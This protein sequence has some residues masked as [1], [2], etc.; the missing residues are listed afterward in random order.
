MG[1]LEMQQ[2]GRVRASLLSFCQKN[3]QI[4]I[5]GAGNYAESCL[6][7]LREIGIVPQGFI[8]TENTLGG[9]FRG[10]PVYEAVTI[11]EDLNERCGIIA[12]FMGANEL[13]LR[14]FIGDAPAIFTLPD[15]VFC[16]FADTV[17]V[18][19]FLSEFQK[20]TKPKPLKPL[21]QWKRILVIR[22]DVLGDLIM[23]TAFLRELRRDCPDAH[24]TLVVHKSNYFLF[25][26]CP[27][28][29]EL[30]LYDGPVMGG[31]ADAQLNHR[32]EIEER[33]RSFNKEHW[34]H[35]EQY[36]VVF[37]PCILLQGRNSLT[38]FLLAEASPSD[39][40]VGRVNSFR[41]D[42]RLLYPYLHEIFSVVSYETE[43]K[44]ETQYMLDMLRGCGCNVADEA[45]ELWIGRED[46]RFAEQLIPR[47]GENTPVIAVG[48]VGSKPTRNWPPGNYQMFIR[49][50]STRFHHAVKFILF[51]GQD[52]EEA[53]ATVMSGIGELRDRVFDIT[54]KTSLAQAAAVMERCALYVGADTGLMHMA[55]ALRKPVVEFSIALPDCEKSNGSHP[56]RMGP[57]GVPSIILRP[58]RA[59]GHC[60]GICRQG[61]AHCITQITVE[62]VVQA[63]QKLLP[64]G[65]AIWNCS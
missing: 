26:E 12:A 10:L 31:H 37:L 55:A 23:T 22:L 18:I 40:F 15:D 51:G 49:E 35:S 60:T 54:G 4:F 7:V 64:S 47:E 2:M 24:I 20:K 50:F 53:A 62:E 29:T 19:P 57:W 8:V 27:Y 28:L 45:L 5:Y 30:L 17:Q 59:V 56:C 42:E 48:L 58:R 33:V 25:K 52:A 65:D 3:P 36:D 21:Q 43:E 38:T 63:G 1:T 14:D 34:Q 13:M 32:E 41:A 61:Y 16:A 46:R 9:T 6:S 39:C 44:H 11:R